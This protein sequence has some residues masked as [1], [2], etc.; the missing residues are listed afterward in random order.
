MT[1][2]V[3]GEISALNSGFTFT[4]KLTEK[5]YEIVAVHQEAKD[6]LE[7]TARTQTNLEQARLLR[8]QKS[9]LLSSVEKSIISSAF[10]A[11]EAA[12][13]TVA[14][15]VEPA[16]A[17]LNVSGGLEAG[18]VR[19]ATRMQF[20]FRDMARLPVSL[21]KLTIAEGKLNMALTTLMGKEGVRHAS[22]DGSTHFDYK[23]P[24]TYQESEFLH[25]S[26]ER[27]VRRRESMASIRSRQDQ[28]DSRSVYGSMASSVDGI[29]ELPDEDDGFS[30]LEVIDTQSFGTPI[31]ATVSEPT[32]SASAYLNPSAGLGAQ[33]EIPRAATPLKGKARSR[34]WLERRL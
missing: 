8:R 33:A 28:A 27:N 24:P 7:V 4:L 9:G 12:L 20:V 17:D 16:R 13:G 15:L 30:T 11:T 10:D 19:L 32:K 18:H 6:L 5:I 34:A 14:K 3:A 21:Q 23:P 22:I 31:Y 2:G 26:R 1:G 29:A 25:R